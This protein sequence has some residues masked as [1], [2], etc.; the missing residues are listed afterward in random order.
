MTNVATGSELA[1]SI[2]AA[3]IE[4]REHGVSDDKIIDAL[5]EAIKGVFEEQSQAQPSF[6]EPAP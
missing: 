1:E 6:G 3:V 2:T 4:A 5:A